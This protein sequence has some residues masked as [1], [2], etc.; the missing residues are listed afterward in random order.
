MNCCCSWASFWRFLWYVA[1][2]LAFAFPQLFVS[3]VFS[4]CSIVFLKITF[5]GTLDC[6]LLNNQEP[7]DVFLIRLVSGFMVAFI[8]Q[9]QSFEL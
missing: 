3:G 2:L 6:G 8:C 7:G 9:E 4:L 1:V 5:W